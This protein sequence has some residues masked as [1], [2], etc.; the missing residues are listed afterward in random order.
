VFRILTANPRPTTRLSSDSSPGV[1]GGRRFGKTR[2]YNLRAGDHDRVELVVERLNFSAGRNTC[3]LSQYDGAG[4]DLE[5]PE[6]SRRVLSSGRND[7][8]PGFGL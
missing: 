3:S 4:F 2:I 5:R 1:S 8:V 6:T 7:L